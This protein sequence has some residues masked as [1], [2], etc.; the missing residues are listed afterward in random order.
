MNS[1]RYCLMFLVLF[2]TS[3]SCSNQQKPSG[4]L[5][6]LTGIWKNEFIRNGEKGVRFWTIKQDSTLSIKETGNGKM[7]STLISELDSTQLFSFIMRPADQLLH[8]TD[9]TFETPNHE[10]I[11]VIFPESKGDTTIKWPMSVYGGQTKYW[12]TGSDSLFMLLGDKKELFTRVVE[13]DKN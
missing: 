6:K 5:E 1:M 2:L 11:A 13:A 10:V 9:S 3:G 8:I 4:N 12:L 7:L